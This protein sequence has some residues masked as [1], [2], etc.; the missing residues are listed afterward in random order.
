VETFFKIVDVRYIVPK[1]AVRFY[2]M[3]VCFAEI[4]W[5][6]REIF[7]YLGLES[8][9]QP[10]ANNGPYSYKIKSIDTAPFNPLETTPL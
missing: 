8:E 1:V 5:L 9:W 10:T 3:S 7:I 2:K 6:L 4:Y